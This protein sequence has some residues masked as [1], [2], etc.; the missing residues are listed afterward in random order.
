MS[1]IKNKTIAI[2]NDLLNLQSRRYIGNKYK[3]SEWIFSIIDKECKGETFADIF[4][5]TGVVSAQANGRYKKVILNDFLYSNYN[6]Y[7][8]FFSKSKFSIDLINQYLKK[9]NSLDPA[10][11]KDNYFSI[12]FGNKYFTA[13]SAKLIGYIREDLEKNKSKMSEKEYYILTTSLLYS[14]DSIANTVGHY[15]AYF[16]NKNYVTKSFSMKMI[17][18]VKTNSA[19]IYREDANT[20][21]KRIKADIVYIDPPYNSRQYSRFYHVLENLIKWQKPKLFGTALKPEPENMSDYCRVSAKDRFA[22]LIKDIKAKYIV[23]SYNNTYESKSNSSEN[24]I[25]HAELLT[26]LN[27]RGKTKIFEKEYRHFNSGKTNFNNHK[28]FLFV[29]YVKDN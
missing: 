6:I 18:P 19:D 5:G 20:L 8:A 26:I 22:E 4:A 2:N 15:D 3:L 17:Q 28:E 24:K 14:A 29:T 27:S 25:T 23:V 12:S 21:V 11:I 10:K 7:Q 9:Y 13:D 16:K 1:Q